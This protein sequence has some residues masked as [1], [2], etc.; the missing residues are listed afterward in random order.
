ME[1]NTLI[2]V[3]LVVLIAIVLIQ[4]IQLIGIAGKLAV[5]GAVTTQVQSQG[6]YDGFSSYEEM[7]EAHHGSAS[8]GSVTGLPQQVGGC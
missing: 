6:S 8:G 3:V 1:N 2:A 5:T 7:M 4:T